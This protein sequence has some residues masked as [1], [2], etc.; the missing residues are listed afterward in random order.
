MASFTNDTIAAALGNAGDQ[1]TLAAQEAGHQVLTSLT[2]IAGVALAAMI[3]GLFFIRLRQPPIVGYIL[4]GVILGPTGLGYIAHSEAI[5]LLAELGVLLLLFLIGMEISIR[6]FVLVLK[7]ALIVVSVQISAAIGLSFLFGQVLGWSIAQSLLLGFIVAISSTA[8][9]IKILDEVD[10]LRTQTGRITIGVMIAQDIAIVPMLII[11]QSFGSADGSSGFGF[12][13]VLLIITSIGF[14]GFLIWFLNRPGKIKLP[15]S[16]HITGKPDIMALSALAFCFCAASLSGLLG[17]SPVYGAFVAG[18]II[19]NS[20]LRAE[21]I[22]LTYPV[23]SILVF[24]FF[25]SVGLLIDLDF[26]WKNFSTVALFVAATVLIKTVLNVYVIRKVG[27][28]WEVAFPAGLAMA[29]IGEFSFILAAAGVQNGVLDADAYRLA[30]AVI[31][32]SLIISP[33]WMSAA[34]RF[35]EI[36]QT[37][38]IDFREALT[39]I[40]A[41]E[42]EELI[43]GKNFL[44]RGV[45][46]ARIYARATRLARHKRQK[47]RDKNTSP[48]DP[49]QSE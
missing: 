39:Q 14:L 24:V 18:L 12:A 4:A 22:Q 31:S 25:L 7:P 19:A 1:T 35:H 40:Y 36:T 41:P 11:V 20:T 48:D 45:Y 27:Q 32:M 33:I 21:M 44:D 49:A 23:Q 26:V 16:D 8:V 43:R 3:L 29:Q 9:A 15:F 42:A 10:E 13:T 30:L 47:A 37:G 5:T 17:L 2:S 46:R 38:L 6:A 34:R 28:E